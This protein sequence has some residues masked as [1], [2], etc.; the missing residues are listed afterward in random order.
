MT[1]R[2]PGHYL[3]TEVDDRWWRR[4]GG[5]GFFARGNGTYWFERDSLCFLRYL[6]SDPLCIHFDE[7]ENIST[8]TWHAGRWG[9]GRQIVKLHWV[10]DEMQL[11]SGFVVGKDE[12]ETE[13]FIIALMKRVN[14]RK[15]I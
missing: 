9:F 15:P 14:Q 12:D 7:I 4:F 10:R 8:G 2:K 5:D 1:E 6:T 11:S 13:D 3:G